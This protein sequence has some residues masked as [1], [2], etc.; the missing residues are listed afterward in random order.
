[1]HFLHI[2]EYSSCFVDFGHGYYVVHLYIYYTISEITGRFW[3]QVSSFNSFCLFNHIIGPYA[4]AFMWET[5]YVM[6]NTLAD[7]ALLKLLKTTY[8]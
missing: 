8:V 3:L 4:L 5:C 7:I 1:M 2:C 6:V